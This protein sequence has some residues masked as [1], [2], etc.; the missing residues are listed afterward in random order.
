MLKQRVAVV[1]GAN[2]GLGLGISRG[3][4][5]QGYRVVMTG[6]NGKKLEAAA[7]RLKSEGLAVETFIVDVTRQADVDALVP[8]LEKNFGRVDVLVNNAGVVL[9]TPNF[10]QEPPSVLRSDPDRVGKTLETNTLG[11]LRMSQALVPLMKRNGYGRIVNMASGMGQLSDM[12]GYWVGYRMSK[13]ALNT[14]TRVLAAE[15]T[16]TPIKV[17]S[18]CPGWVKT[19][20]GGP[21]ADRLVE[22]AVPGIIWAATLPADGPS[23]GF[24]RDGE[25]ISW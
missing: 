6:R 18:I 21:H 4:A 1:T 20:M 16:D 14:V 13:T 24:F 17:N 12:G 10:D 11:P 19:D 5:E 25:P 23:G 3:L 22:E 9:E 2:R 7:G 8:W 15:L